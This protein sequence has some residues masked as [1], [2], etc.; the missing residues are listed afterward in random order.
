[1]EGILPEITNQSPHPNKMAGQ[2]W[3]YEPM[4]EEIKVMKPPTPEEVKE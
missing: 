1:M 4:E 2:L 3:Q